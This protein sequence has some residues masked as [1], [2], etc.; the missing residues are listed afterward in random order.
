MNNKDIQKILQQQR[1]KS[2]MKDLSASQINKKIGHA[3][4][5]ENRRMIPAEDHEQLLR[6]YWS[7]DKP[8]PLHYSK[9]LGEKYG[10]KDVQNIVSNVHNT[11]PAE[12][13][14]ALK[15]AYNTTYPFNEQRSAMTK[16]QH[17]T[18]KRKQAGNNIS[19]SKNTV[20]PEDAIVIYDRSLSCKEGRTHAYYKQIAKE[21]GVSMGKIQGVV[22][23]HHP[24]LKDKDVDHDVRQHEIKYLG[25]YKF[26]SPEGKEYVF[27][28]LYDVGA[29]LWKTEH[30][31]TKTAQQNWSKGR[32]WFEQSEPNTV[33]LKR[34]RYWK[35]WS[36]C[37]VIT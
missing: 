2:P 10:A 12:E 13:Y 21:Y 37:N 36:Y 29:W 26:T 19:L 7:T 32:M 14:S 5:I 28:N 20:S 25:I 4:A 24:A 23:G 11:I 17:A 9:M 33:Y 1:A 27:D 15:E 8:R 18:G 3:E 34:K 6:T 35:G 31:I 16:E 30:N 22:N